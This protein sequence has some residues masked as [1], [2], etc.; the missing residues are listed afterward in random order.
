[1]IRRKPAAHKAAQR[2]IPSRLTGR[3]GVGLAMFHLGRL[4]YEFVATSEGSHAGDLWV[5]FG[6]GPEAVEVKASTTGA[7]HLRRPQLMRVRRVVFVNVA[8]G[9]AWLA[10]VAAVLAVWETTKQ[11]GRNAC[12]MTEKQLCSG[13]VI[14]WH[15]Q[16]PRVVPKPS[17]PAKQRYAKTV[18]RKLADGT[19]RVYQYIR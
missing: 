5:D 14:A 11:R 6:D 7:W 3:A 13:N 10:D 12:T 9:T 2:D 17:R 4:G 19:I 18:K 16:V 1:V 8:D 15:R